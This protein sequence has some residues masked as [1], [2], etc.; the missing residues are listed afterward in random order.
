VPQIKLKSVNELGTLSDQAEGVLFQALSHSMRRA[1][2]K[3]VGSEPEG[4][5]YTQL[6]TELGLS[7]GKMNYH[8]EQLEGIVE[9]N[10]NRR[11]VLSPLGKKALNQLRMMEKEFSQ[12]DEK[13]LN[14]TWKAQ[15]TSLE[16][17]LKG[18]MIAGIIGA[19]FVLIVFSILAYVTVTS[20]SVP[21]FIYILLPLLI[22]FDL[23]L[24]AVLIRALQKT[25]EWLRRFEHRF[26]E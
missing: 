2:I 10:E 9:K 26:L 6:I 3:I 11:Y 19:L 8:L 23:G 12:E 14:T 25:P 22:A 18:F 17:T 15:K 13:Y 24:L 16:P 21:I 1:I 20:N 4:F 5:L 7:T